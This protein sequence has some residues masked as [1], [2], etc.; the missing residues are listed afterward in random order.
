M[1]DKTIITP[2]NSHIYPGLKKNEFNR[3]QQ[4]MAN[5]RSNKKKTQQRLRVTIG[6]KSKQFIRPSKSVQTK[7]KRRQTRK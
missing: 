5:I 3:R 7:H 4:N 1:A 6:L 2:N